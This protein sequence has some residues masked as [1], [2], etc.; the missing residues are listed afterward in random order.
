MSPLI[1]AA[2]DIGRR[3]VRS[4]LTVAGISIG[5]ATLVLLG[6]LSE[7]LTRL[8][9]GGREFGTGQINVAGAGAS[10][11]VGMM[12]GSLLTGDQISALA[13][14]PGIT[15]VAPIIMFPISDN[16]PA[17]PFTLTPLVFGC[18]VEALLL[19]RR[20]TPP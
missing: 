15:K 3:P 18:D 2:R 1:A 7:R 5:V 13:N 11:A 9:N 17:V 14:V 16:A 6:A 4:A 20:M 12:R 8:V 10:A 19:N